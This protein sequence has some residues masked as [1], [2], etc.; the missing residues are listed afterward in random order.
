MFGDCAQSLRP[1]PLFE[2]SLLFYR[3]VARQFVYFHMI[4]Q[5][6]LQHEK[7][8]KVDTVHESID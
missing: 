1:S 7:A 5:R 4:V 3:N 8:R 2:D 6:N